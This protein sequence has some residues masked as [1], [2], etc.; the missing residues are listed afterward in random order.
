MI[1]IFSLNDKRSIAKTDTVFSDLLFGI[2]SLQL[3][4]V[5]GQL[6]ASRTFNDDCTSFVLVVCYYTGGLLALSTL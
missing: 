1:Q 4:D 5:L 2:G 3:S 6:S